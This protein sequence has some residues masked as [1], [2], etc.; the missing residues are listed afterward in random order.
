MISIG[1]CR[2]RIAIERKT[3]G[4]SDG[5]GGA[6]SETWTTLYECWAKL[7]PQTGREIV[8]AD[9]NVHRLTH[10]V[11]VRFRA[12]VTTA[13]RVNYQGRILAILGTREL[14]ENGRW[15]EIM[16]EEGAPS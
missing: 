14:M 7:E 4:S 6:V 13:M 12:G 10:R 16:C 9:Q 15:L 11:T 5:A 2:H 8:A 1:Q 3:R